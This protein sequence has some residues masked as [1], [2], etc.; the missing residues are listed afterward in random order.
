MTVPTTYILI[1]L[2]PISGQ[3]VERQEAAT[4]YATCAE[5][6]DAALAGRGLPLDVDGPASAARCTPGDRFR[7]GWD[8]IRGY[9]CRG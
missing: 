6:A 3:W 1:A 8:C 2:W 4:S 5:A 7:P 9:N